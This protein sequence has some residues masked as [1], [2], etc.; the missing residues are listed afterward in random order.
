M[1]R[2]RITLEDL[3]EQRLIMREPGSGTR[4][5][6]ER[7]FRQNGIE[8]VSR[9]E[10]TSN[11][12]IKQVVEAGLGI[13]IVSRH[14]V[15]LELS[16][17]RLV[18]V[19]AETFPIVRKWYIAQRVNKRLSPAAAPGASRRVVRRSNVWTALPSRCRA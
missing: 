12:A 1:H 3:A 6:I 18:E 11:E 13:A 8:P 15:E 19:P 4:H 17:G 7:V 2:G 10:M 9:T 16:V 14:T 5:A